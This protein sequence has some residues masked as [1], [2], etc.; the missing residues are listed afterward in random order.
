MFPPSGGLLARRLEDERVGDDHGA[1]ALGLGERPGAHTASH[2][3]L[4]LGVAR[5]GLG[6]GRGHHV[7]LGGDGEADGHLAAQLREAV[8]EAL[9]AEAD[10]PA[11]ALDDLADEFL[12]E[13]TAHRGLLGSDAHLHALLGTTEAAHATA[14]AAHAT[15]TALGAHAADADDLTAAAAATAAAQTHADQA[16]AHAARLGAEHVAHGTLEVSTQ[17]ATGEQA[18]GATLAAE[19]LGR[20]VLRLGLLVR[21]GGVGGRGLDD[22]LLGLL[23]VFLL[24]LGLLRLLLGL[25]LVEVLEEL[26]LLRL[27]RLDDEL[28]EARVAARQLVRELIARR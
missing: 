8:E 5:R 19:D 12:V 4:Q 28:G 13:R 10:L 26:V 1:A 21:L 14:V 9:V 15:A 17:G 16:V 7:A 11:V 18:R 2:A 6:H 3:L 23:G 20:H 25:L 27:G 22:L 24:R